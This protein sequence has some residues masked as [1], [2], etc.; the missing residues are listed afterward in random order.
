[1]HLSKQEKDWKHPKS[2]K[3]P[4]LLQQKAHLAK[5]SICS[6][7]CHSNNY[8][9]IALKWGSLYHTCFHSPTIFV[10]ISK[11]YELVLVRNLFLWKFW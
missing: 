5:S 10:V 9:V 4:N 7:I 3:E 8:L 2:L 11:N 1:M 6:Q